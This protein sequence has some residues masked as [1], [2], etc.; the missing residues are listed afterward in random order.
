MESSHRLIEN[1][2]ERCFV[3]ALRCQWGGSRESEERRVPRVGRERHAC[4]PLVRRCRKYLDAVAQNKR[5]YF[6][7]WVC[8]W[9]WIG[10]WLRL[11]L[12]L[13]V[14]LRCSITTGRTAPAEQRA[15]R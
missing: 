5:H 11:W 13:S 15:S 1:G 2:L 12:R 4:Q 8:V 6:L 9:T 10:H 3:E 7:T 14:R